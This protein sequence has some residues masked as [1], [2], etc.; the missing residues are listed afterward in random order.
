[1]PETELSAGP[2]LFE[3]KL[4]SKLAFISQ[5]CRLEGYGLFPSQSKWTN[6]F[7]APSIRR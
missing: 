1:M 7:I 3:I 2:R 6:L 5:S 4:A